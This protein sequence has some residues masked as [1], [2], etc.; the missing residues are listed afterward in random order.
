MPGKLQGYTKY[1]I[2]YLPDDNRR[3]SIAS[4]KFEGLSSAA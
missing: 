1:L 4:T 3:A 2:L